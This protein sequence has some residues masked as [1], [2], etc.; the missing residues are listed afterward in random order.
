MLPLLI[1]ELLAG[2]DGGPPALTRDVVEDSLLQAVSAKTPTMI[3]PHGFVCIF[4]LALL[5]TTGHCGAGHVVKL[6]SDGNHSRKRGI[7]TAGQAAA[8]FIDRPIA[9]GFLRIDIALVC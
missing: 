2:A 7:L 6:P 1:S 8:L 3:G 5:R 4:R 9:C